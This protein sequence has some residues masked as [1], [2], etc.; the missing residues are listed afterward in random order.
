[1]A[2]M[3]EEPPR[4]MEPPTL[5]E[6]LHALDALHRHELREL[7]PT[8]SE[9]YKS[10]ARKLV[11]ALK[12]E[13]ATTI[14]GPDAT[15][16]LGAC[17]KTVLLVAA[18]ARRSL[19][20]RRIKRANRAFAGKVGRWR[21][22]TQILAFLDFEVQD[23]VVALPTPAAHDVLEAKTAALRDAFAFFNANAPAP[24]RAAAAPAPPPAPPPPPAPAPA[25]FTSAQADSLR[26]AL[27]DHASAT[28][29]E[30]AREEEVA[31]AA[32]AA[33]DLRA[34][35]DADYEASLAADRAKALSLQE[36][37]EEEE[38]AEDAAIAEMHRETP[39]ERRR[40]LADA[41]QRRFAAD[42]G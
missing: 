39:A 33:R 34:E 37:E 17:A 31:A 16:L 40:R 25:P 32:R 22:S 6:R 28:A 42:D 21:A 26:R 20:L 41:F 24:P 15:V 14:P 3:V 8:D 10:H 5:E 38:E 9:P 1:M 2:T 7:E 12:V 11:A 30:R 35:Q 36:E 29:D 23:A 13:I 19:D 27:Q 18:N 4:V